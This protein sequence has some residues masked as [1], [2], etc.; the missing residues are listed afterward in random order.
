MGADFR[1]GVAGKPISHSL[2][3][4]LFALVH[5]HLGL[6]WPLPERRVAGTP[7]AMLPYLASPPVAPSSEL[8]RLVDSITGSIESVAG[9]PAPAGGFSID[10]S[11]VGVVQVSDKVLDQ[12]IWFSITTPLK[13]QVPNGPFN[14]VR[15][16]EDGVHC[17]N[18]DGWG[19]VAL[20]RHL[21]ID[22][23]QGALLDL[24]GG[25]SSATAGAT[26]WLQTGGRVRSTGGRRAL[27]AELVSEVD[28]DEAARLS[29]DFDAAPGEPAASE[30]GAAMR[31]IPAYSESFQQGEGS[32]DGRWLLVFQHLLA[33]AALFAPQHA[34]RLPGPE[35]MFARL[36][37][38]E[39]ESEKSGIRFV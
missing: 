15:A 36:R 18:T 13:H 30:S 7:F 27:A 21:G 32:L 28:A 14:C 34:E 16:D 3:P 39:S 38:L 12:R 24:R 26:A 25:G 4:Q 10:P 8:E 1:C 31:L 37:A 20:A 11:L 23:E 6:E 29:A 17:A 9:S 22:V 33:W 19:L 2:S 35:L 5:S